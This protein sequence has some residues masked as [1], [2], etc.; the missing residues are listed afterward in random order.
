MSGKLTRELRDLAG[1]L[2]E[3]FTKFG[4][5][6]DLRWCA[7]SY[8]ALQKM[9][10]MYPN[11]CAHMEALA[12]SKHK[13][14]DTAK[15][16]LPKLRSV[17]FVK[18]LHYMIDFLLLCTILS[19]S[20]QAESLL[21]CDVPKKLNKCIS[22]LQRLKAGNGHYMRQFVANFDP[23]T[24]MFRG[25]ALGY[26][27]RFTRQARIE[28]VISLEE[29]IE[30]LELDVEDEEEEFVDMDDEFEDEQS[31]EEIPDLWDENDLDDMEV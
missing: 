11:L 31:D 13:H 18:Y 17:K 12:A 8:R 25:V 30:T 16:L 29:P 24:K 6:S 28:D 1:I 4:Q 3:E 2:D 19:K 7:R 22:S 10:Q 23:K 20:F 27:G 15:G 26:V 21:I 5:L 14:A 9:I